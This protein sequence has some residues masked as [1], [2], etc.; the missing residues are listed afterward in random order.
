ME[1]DFKTRVINLLESIGDGGEK[2]IF[3]NVEKINTLA[4]YC[5]G[6]PLYHNSFEKGKELFEKMTPE[7]IYQHMIRKIVE[8]PTTFH[9]DAAVIL[10][11]PHLADSI[12]KIQNEE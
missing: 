2:A 11:V 3:A 7:E 6:I 8:S 9:R 4:E 1:G 12:Q 5:K 10:T